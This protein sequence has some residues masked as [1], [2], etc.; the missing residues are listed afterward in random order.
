MELCGLDMVNKILQVKN[1]AATRWLTLAFLPKKI[2]GLKTAPEK[3][4]DYLQKGLLHTGST[5]LFN[6]LHIGRHAGFQLSAMVVN[7]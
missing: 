4:W 3:C 2:L 1:L 6:K 5:L 7:R